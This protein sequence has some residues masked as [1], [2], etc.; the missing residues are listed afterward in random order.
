MS[1][2]VQNAAGRLVPTEINGAQAVPFAGV[3]RLT[4]SAGVCELADAGEPGEL[5]R[6]AD[7]MLYLAKAEGR[8]TVRRHSPGPLARI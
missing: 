4:I 7:R 6:L 1:R 8:N 5:V 2:L 3:G